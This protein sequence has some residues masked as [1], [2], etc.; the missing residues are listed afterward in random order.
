MNGGNDVGKKKQ[1]APDKQQLKDALADDL[2]QKLQQMKSELKEED[3]KRQACERERL[4]KQR[5]EKEK[6]KSF[7][8]LLNESALD[9]K[10]YK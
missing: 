5:K 2:K 1:E 4:I 6:N 8:E 7:E 3:E 10:Q 9:W